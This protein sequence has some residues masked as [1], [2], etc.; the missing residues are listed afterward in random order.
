MNDYNKIHL[1]SIFGTKTYLGIITNWHLLKIKYFKNNEKSFV[2][3]ISCLFSIYFMK[4][5]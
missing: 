1:V 2:F 3:H 5:L 4:I